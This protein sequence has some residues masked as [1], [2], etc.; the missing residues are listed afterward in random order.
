MAVSDRTVK[1]AAASVPKDTPVV[2]V[3]WLPVMVTRVPPLALPVVAVIAVTAGAVAADTAKWSDDP[4]LDVPL[5]V[6]TVMSTVAAPSAG[7][8]AVIEVPEITV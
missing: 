8:T 4:V 6:V 7:E 5:G 2:P 1:L 3:K